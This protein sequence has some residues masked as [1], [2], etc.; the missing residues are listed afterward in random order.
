MTV[1][2]VDYGEARVGLALVDA[3]APVPLPRGLGTIHRK[4]RR[5]AV[6]AII[7]LARRHGAGRIV[8]GIPLAPDGGMGLRAAQVRNF[9]RDLAAAGVAVILQ[10]ERDSSREAME[11]LIEA[12]VPQKKR[13]ERLDEMAAVIILERWLR[14]A[15]GGARH[16]IARGDVGGDTEVAPDEEIREVDRNQDG[17]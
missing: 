3:A 10:D 4:G 12:G 7:D 9:G 5:E 17:L 13:A 11:R 15:E 16:P 8:V 14:A 6:D 2:G 1:L